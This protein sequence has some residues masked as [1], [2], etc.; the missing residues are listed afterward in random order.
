VVATS[1]ALTKT[2]ANRLATVAHDGFARTI[3]PAHRPSDGDVIFTLAT[4]QQPV[5]A[6]EYASIEALATLAVERAV[7]RAVQRAT[8]LAG[9]PAVSEIGVAQRRPRG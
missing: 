3:W 5:E 4:Q 2:Q 7:L 1:A 6:A 9:V 8:S